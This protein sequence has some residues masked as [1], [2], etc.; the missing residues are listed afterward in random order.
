MLYSSR[1]SICSSSVIRKIRSSAYYQMSYLYFFT[2]TR[3][4]DKFPV[5]LFSHKIPNTLSFD[6]YWY[7]I[8][9]EHT[10]FLFLF[11]ITFLI[12]RPGVSWSN[13]WKT[14]RTRF[15]R[16]FAWP[17]LISP[18]R[19]MSVK[20]ARSQLLIPFMENNICTR[21]KITKKKKKTR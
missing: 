12:L 19:P 4:N 11:F 15:S 7:L 10:G 13:A 20:G 8:L 6:H 5:K 16:L 3:L 14:P 18:R 21:Q 2:S 1:F 17:Y 9:I